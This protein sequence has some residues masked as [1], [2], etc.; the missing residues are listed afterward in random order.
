MKGP[1]TRP[2]RFSLHYANEKGPLARACVFGVMRQYNWMCRRL[3]A[4][5]TRRRTGHTHNCSPRS[6][7]LPRHRRFRLTST[8]APNDACCGHILPSSLSHSFVCSICRAFYTNYI[9]FPD[10]MQNCLFVTTPAFYAPS[11]RTRD[12]VSPRQRV[13][14]PRTS[15]AIP[16]ASRRADRRVPAQRNRIHPYFLP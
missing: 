9:S 2:F 6:G 5:A 3:Y 11:D 15:S 13:C 10:I 1:L 7:A 8:C 4:N 12:T 16:P 14:T